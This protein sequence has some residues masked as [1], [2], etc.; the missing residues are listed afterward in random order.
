VKENHKLNHHWIPAFAG[1]TASFVHFD[2]V[3]DAGGRI[4]LFRPD[5]FPLRQHLLGDIFEF[6]FRNRSL[7][8]IAFFFNQFDHF[9]DLVIRSRQ[10]N[11]FRKTRIE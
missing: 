2:T 1:M 10:A 6:N 5:S 7:Y 11:R 9:L 3:S 8:D 4:S